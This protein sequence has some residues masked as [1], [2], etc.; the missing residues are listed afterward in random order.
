MNYHEFAKANNVAVPKN[1]PIVTQADPRVGKTAT[2]E[3][4]YEAGGA[5]V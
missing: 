1:W 3:L 2:A 5:L 4:H